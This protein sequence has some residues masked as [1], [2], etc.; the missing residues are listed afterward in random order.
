MNK[1]GFK[2]LAI[3]VI[4]GI[5]LL[6]NRS[7]FTSSNSIHYV[8]PKA[9]IDWDNLTG[10]T[11]EQHFYANEAIRSVS[12]TVYSEEGEFETP[13]SIKLFKTASGELIGQGT[14]VARSINQ[15]ATV[16]YTFPDTESFALTEYNLKI[17]SEGTSPILQVKTN[18]GN[19]DETM[20]IDGTQVKGRLI[21]KVD[22]ANNLFFSFALLTMILLVVSLY[23]LFFQKQIFLKPERYFLVLALLSGLVMTFIVPSGQ[24]P[25]SGDH[26]LRAFD[27]SYGNYR[28][29]L[30]KVND[31]SIQMP[32]NFEIFDDTIIEPHLNLGLSRVQS[33][34]TD[35]FDSDFGK[36]Y[37]YRYKKQ[38]STLVYLPQGLGLYLGRVWGLNEFNMLS[39]A[40]LLN[41]FTYIGLTYLSIKIMPIYKTFMLAVGLLPMSIYQASSISA[42]AIINGF[43]FLFIA[44][45]IQLSLQVKKISLIQ[46]ILP[47]FLLYIVYLAKPAYL[48]VALL[49]FIIPLA[50]YHKLSARIMRI[51]IF[52]GFSVSVAGL[53]FAFV[54]GRLML[55]E[56]NPVY[57]DQLTF[58]LHNLIPT[59]RIFLHTLSQNAVQYL[60]WLNTLG[61]L[62]Y[63]LGFLVFAIPI[64]LVWVGLVDHDESMQL[65]LLQKLLILLALGGT[66]AAIFIGLYIYDDVNEIGGSLMLGVQ[67]R[68]F[69]P[70][71]ILPFL[72]IKSPVQIT[73]DPFFT[74]RVA[75]FSGLA[76]T[77]SALTL[78]RMI[79]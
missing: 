63:S 14:Q 49:I 18:V 15:A 75:G 73:K 79:Y 64:F 32:D 59:V 46:L 8:N 53:L 30:S 22:Y 43:L 39:L 25:D 45:I 70:L 54:S 48:P 62:T 1:P 58:V 33:M 40:R 47:S 56:G 27:V 35:Q 17:E 68:Y 11:I 72:V 31:R 9:E 71:F 34:L 52:L 21:F 61:W 29:L 65:N 20:S 24:E 13:I 41:L 16:E 74:H 57:P 4:L 6:I 38:Y 7:V 66:V 3:M 12:L 60:V 55:A 69:I 67:G 51:L 23:I 42:D 78:I 2:W 36:N 76:L 44:M 37:D 28:P 50:N 26:I 77:Y 10:H 19:Y 5:T